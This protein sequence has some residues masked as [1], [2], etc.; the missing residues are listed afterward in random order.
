MSEDWVTEEDLQS[1]EEEQLDFFDYAWS[2]EEPT[3]EDFEAWE[4]DS[5]TLNY[6]QQQVVKNKTEEDIEIMEDLGDEVLNVGSALVYLRMLCLCCDKAG[7]DFSE[8]GNELLKES[9]GT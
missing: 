4:M 7:M 6:L 2:E 5:L 9:K 8:L 3:V 1:F